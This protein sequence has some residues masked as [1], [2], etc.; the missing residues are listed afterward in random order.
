MSACY[1][2]VP[3]CNRYAH[4]LSCV[5]L[6]V[7][8]TVY[9][10]LLQRCPHLVVIHL[11]LITPELVSILDMWSGGHVRHLDELLID[12]FT[13]QTS[14]SLSSKPPRLPNCTVL[15]LTSTPPSWF[16]RTV[17]RV[18]D[19]HL[20][21]RVVGSDAQTAHHGLETLPFA[22]LLRS[23]HIHWLL[24]TTAGH[25]YGADPVPPLLNLPRLAPR[26]TA[27]Q[28]LHLQHERFGMH[29]R[30]VASLFYSRV[31][32]SCLFARC[33]ALLIGCAGASHEMFSFCDADAQALSYNCPSL[34][35]LRCDL[36]WSV[37]PDTLA[38]L[39]MWCPGLKELH[40]TDLICNTQSLDALWPR[41]GALRG[42]S[43]VPLGEGMAVA[44][45]CTQLEH[46]TIAAGDAVDCLPLLTRSLATLS[47]VVRYGPGTLPLHRDSAYLRELQEIDCQTLLSLSRLQRL[48]SLAPRLRVLSARLAT[49]RDPDALTFSDDSEG[50][51]VVAP[52]LC[53]RTLRLHWIG[54]PR[55]LCTLLEQQCPAL[56]ECCL[57]GFMN[58]TSVLLSL[59]QR[60]PHLRVLHV[61]CSVVSFAL[62]IDSNC[63]FVF[64]LLHLTP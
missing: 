58:D 16:I 60:C 39:L 12:A 18:Q 22:H 11:Q 28:S 9:A 54:A 37:T 31:F 20:K 55:D 64:S 46:L 49:D 50:A 14:V 43:V 52:A 19:L 47:L 42:L 21:F 23:L 53:L 15:R 33:L 25:R 4:L 61:C 8:T 35:S 27:L 13:E 48:L 26:L 51:V 29:G 5:W 57:Y 32:L 2:Q 59:T 41:C 3:L 34:T 45:H 62:V 24:S 10:S 36:S 30:A 63:H 40:L 1:S 44:Q 7:P 6:R 56:E 17:S 38:E